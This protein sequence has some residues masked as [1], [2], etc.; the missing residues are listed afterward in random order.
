MKRLG[1]LV[2]LLLVLGQSSNAAFPGGNG[3]LLVGDDDGRLWMMRSDGVRGPR[4]PIESS[5]ADVSADGRWISFIASGTR[6]NPGLW[7]ARARTDG[8][9]FKILTD[10]VDP[11]PLSYGS[12]TWSPD[13]TQIVFVGQPNEQQGDTGGDLYIVPRNGGDLERV[14]DTPQAE[15]EPAWSP[16][17]TT[18]AYV[19][20][21]VGPFCGPDGQLWTLKVGSTDPPTL[22]VQN[23]THPD[24]SPNG[25]RIVYECQRDVLN[26][27]RRICVYDLATQQS[28]VIYQ[29]FSPASYPV[30]SPN[31]K[32]IAVTIEPLTEENN[33]PEIYTMRADGSDLRRITDNRRPEILMDWVA[34]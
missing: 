33:D 34:G 31:G 14:T 3:P 23:A 28:T 26:N 8:S 4:L 1:L 12:P 11:L 9:R 15:Q 21:E 27:E 16:D 29:R 24:W 19:R 18:I 20:C 13:G 25:T 22:L 32:R 2:A 7:I 10:A 30:W 6:E 17:G 5:L